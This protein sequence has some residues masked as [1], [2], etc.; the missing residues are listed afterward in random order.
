MRK[1]AAAAGWSVA[2]LSALLFTWL[3]FYYLGAALARAPFDF[4]T[5]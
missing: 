3:V 1:F 5:G 2:A 4:H